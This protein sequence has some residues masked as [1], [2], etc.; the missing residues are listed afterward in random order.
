LY[1]RISTGVF[2]FD[3]KDWAEISVEAK[4]LIKKMLVVDPK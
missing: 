1:D 2:K 4:N 3:E